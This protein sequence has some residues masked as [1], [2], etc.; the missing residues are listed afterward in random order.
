MIDPHVHCRDWNES[1]K[2]TIAHA[3]LVAERAGISGIFDMPNTNPPIISRELAIKRIEDAGKVDSKVFYGLYFGL[4]SDPKQIEEAVQTYNELFPSVVGFK[5]YA[6]HSVG[7]LA[8]SV[9]EEQRRI[10][11]TLAELGYKGVVAVHCEKESL[12][13]QELWNPHYPRTH[14]LARPA[15]AETESIKDQ[16][17]FASESDFKGTLHIAHISH[18]ESV[19]L[20]N[21]ARKNTSLKITCGVT[22]HHCLLGNELMTGEN[23][24]LYKVNPPLRSGADCEI[25]VKYLHEGLIDFIETDHAPHTLHEKLNAPYMS[26]FPG[27]P[28]VPHFLRFLLHIG[29]SEERITYRTHQRICEAFNIDIKDTP[30]HVDYGLEQEYEVDVYEPIRQ[31]FKQR[32]IS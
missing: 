18:P 5:I 12:F 6:G 27:L 30:M 10:Y 24:I 13:N 31:K 26:G 22:P 25:M 29:F 21:Q 11:K 9:E 4:T 17:H 19:L 23:G 1:H 15:I 7:N 14:S 8:I 32:L 28:F 3:L 16:I 2:E 20:V